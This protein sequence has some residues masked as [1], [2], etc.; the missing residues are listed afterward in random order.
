MLDIGRALEWKSTC[1]ILSPGI[2]VLTRIVGDIR[3]CHL[4][5]RRHLTPRLAV[6]PL[7]SVASRKKG[8]GLEIRVGHP[9]DRRDRLVVSV[10]AIGG[11][12]LDD[13]AAIVRERIE[14]DRFA[15]ACDSFVGIPRKCRQPT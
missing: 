5:I 12:K 7:L 15:G 10:G 11:Q 4:L 13:E 2:T 1:P 9:R 8:G 14:A 6:A 3:G